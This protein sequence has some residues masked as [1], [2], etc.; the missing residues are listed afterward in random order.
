[1]LFLDTPTLA[2]RALIYAAKKGYKISATGK[3]VNPVGKIL[4]GCVRNEY[5]T[6]CIQ[7]ETKSVNIFVHRLQAYQKFGDKIFLEAIVVR[8]KDNNKLNNLPDNILIGND[9]ANFTDIP[10]AQRI[11]W[12]QDG[13]PRQRFS[14]EDIVN[15]RK[16][17]GSG[18]NN[19]EICSKYGLSRPKL[20]KIVNRT[21]YAHEGT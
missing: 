7:Y 4:D 2:N 20:S 9:S 15:I 12:S 14:D 8:H 1:V 11:K 17:H 3:I 5:L 16:M 18:I 13:N 10:K 21:L 6:F 19:K